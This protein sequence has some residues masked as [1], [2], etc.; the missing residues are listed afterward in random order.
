M[1]C[2]KVAFGTTGQNILLMRYHNMDHVSQAVKAL[3]SRSNA[4]D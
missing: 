2:E 3:L 4:T 1:P